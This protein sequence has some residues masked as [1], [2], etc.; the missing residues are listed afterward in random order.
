[1][2]WSVKTRLLAGTLGL[3]GVCASPEVD[4]QRI[5][6]GATVL[7]DGALDEDEWIGLT[8]S[9]TQNNLAVQCIRV[10]FHL[11]L[12]LRLDDA[13]RRGPG[14][15]TLFEVWRESLRRYRQR[16]VTQVLMHL[17]PE[18]TGNTWAT[19]QTP[20]GRAQYLAGL[21]RIL[22]EFRG[23]VDLVELPEQANARGTGTA[24]RMSPA[25]YVDLVAGAENVRRRV[26]FQQPARCGPPQVAAGA[27][28]VHHG[29]VP[30]AQH[31]Y[32]YLRAALE[33]AASNPQWMAL[34]RAGSRVMD[35]LAVQEYFR[36]SSQ[37]AVDHGNAG[38]GGVDLFAE[39]LRRYY[40][41]ERGEHPRLWITGVGSS[42]DDSQ[43]QYFWQGSYIRNTMRYVM[44]SPE[45]PPVEAVTFTEMLDDR[46]PDA[47]W[48]LHRGS[49]WETAVAR[50]GYVVFANEWAV[51]R[52]VLSA[53]MTFTDLLGV[54]LGPGH[55]RH[56]GLRIWNMGPSL[57]S[58]PRWDATWGLTIA[59]AEGCP[60]AAGEINGVR[61]VAAGPPGVMPGIIVGRSLPFRPSPALIPTAARTVEIEIEAPST[62]GQ[63]LMAAQMYDPDAGFFGNAATLSVTVVADAGPQDTGAPEGGMA[64]AGLA[65]AGAAEAGTVDAGTVDAGAA[66]AGE[67]SA[68]D[69]TMDRGGATDGPGL[70]DAVM[71]SSDVVAPADVQAP[72][73]VGAALGSDAVVGR[74][75][76]GTGGA[77]D[78]CGCRAGGPTRGRGGGIVFGMILFV[79]VLRRRRERHAWD[80]RVKSSSP[81]P[82]PDS[83]G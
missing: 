65:D 82:S 54:T 30:V 25:D 74:A 24:P 33:A 60:F 58:T 29:K 13:L 81:G 62:P 39:E 77:T 6:A 75:D 42:T 22:T 8:G 49:R 46:D 73:D 20:A 28:L 44:E 47:F 55:T 66:D 5:C 2:V 67:V 9:L 79:E 70:P 12:W 41:P 51:R 7:R 59:Q 4:A 18:A 61:W 21:E 48:G 15:R 14:E 45:C 43:R 1:M 83:G 78:G 16:G 36:V 71:G 53:R 35:H 63:Y 68:A 69:V 72:H 64:D 76:G 37:P 17:P 3:I 50:H 31:G 32:L 40:G 11:D 10:G 19:L 27:L 23:L 26:P 57:D 56:V 34:R 52:P 80:V 38:L